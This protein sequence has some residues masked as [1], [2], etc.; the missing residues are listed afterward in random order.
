MVNI[1]QRLKNCLKMF[2]QWGGLAGVVSYLIEGE[3]WNAL[4]TAVIFGVLVVLV[5][6]YFSKMP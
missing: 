6:K 3:I 2:T 1:P 5:D 4:F